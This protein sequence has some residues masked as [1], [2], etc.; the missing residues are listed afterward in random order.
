MELKKL[1]VLML[2]LVLILSLCACG[3]EAGE[4]PKPGTNQSAPAAT[5]KAEPVPEEFKDHAL[6]SKVYGT[7]VFEKWGDHNNEYN[8]YKSLTINEDGTGIVDGTSVTWKISGN[9]TNDSILVLLIYENDVCIYGARFY[10]S[11]DVEGN[12]K[13]NL[14]AFEGEYGAML[15]TFFNHQ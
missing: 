10:E 15:Q 6:L 7:W 5:D 9:Q 13:I 1:I 12:T 8:L 4:T 11:T 14:F 3:G 2:V